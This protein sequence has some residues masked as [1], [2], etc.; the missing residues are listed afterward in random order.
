MW[1]GEV[2]S[3]NIIEKEGKQDEMEEPFEDAGV[4][5]EAYHSQTTAWKK[6]NSFL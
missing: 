2:G 5:D 1:R 3:Q 6:V 4:K